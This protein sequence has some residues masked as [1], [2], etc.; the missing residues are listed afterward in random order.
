[1]VWFLFIGAL[2]IFGEVL[3]FQVTNI[4]PELCLF[5]SFCLEVESTEDPLTHTSTVGER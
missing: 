1:M 5:C 4:V 2:S 3:I